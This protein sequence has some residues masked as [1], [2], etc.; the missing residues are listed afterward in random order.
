MRGDLFQQRYRDAKPRGGVTTSCVRFV[1]SRPEIIFVRVESGG[2]LFVAYG[3][4]CPMPLYFLLTGKEFVVCCVKG[5]GS[6]GQICSACVRVVFTRLPYFW[7]T[8]GKFVR[9]VRSI[10]SVGRFAFT[11]PFYC[12]DQFILHFSFLAKCCFYPRPHSPSRN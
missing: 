3:G 7:R 12:G 1:S 9:P 10:G 8:R 6:P 4:V 2:K 5:I 11:M